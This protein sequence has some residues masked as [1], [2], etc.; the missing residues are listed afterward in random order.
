MGGKSAWNMY[1]ID[2]N[3]EYCVILHLVGYTWK[4]TLTMHGPMNVKKKQDTHWISYGGTQGTSDNG[5]EQDSPFPS[6][7][8]N[9]PPVIQPGSHNT[10]SYPSCILHE[11]SITFITACSFSLALTF[12]R[13]GSVF[14]FYCTVYEKVLYGTE[15]DKITKHTEFFKN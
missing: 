6:P 14:K 7:E 2:S 1:S 15:K 12:I 13:L 10:E 9:S 11:I 8:L 5:F 4:N 3:K